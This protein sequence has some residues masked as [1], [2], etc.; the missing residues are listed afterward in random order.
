[1]RQ[2]PASPSSSTSPPSTSHGKID[3]EQPVTSAPE[4][5]KRQR[6]TLNKK[7]IATSWGNFRLPPDSLV[8]SDDHPPIF[9]RRA[10]R[11]SSFISTGTGSVAR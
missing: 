5:K 11:I 9:K 3:K 2:L 10:S 8:S 4:C 6:A 7:S 1:M